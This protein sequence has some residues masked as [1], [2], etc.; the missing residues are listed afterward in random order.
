MPLVVRSGGGREG[1]AGGREGTNWNTGRL[2]CYQ[3]LPIIAAD[4]KALLEGGP[5]DVEEGNIP[6]HVTLTLALLILRLSNYS[7]PYCITPNHHHHFITTTP[8][9][10]S[11]HHHGVKFTHACHSHTQTYFL[12][13]TF[14]ITTSIRVF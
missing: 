10:P 2:V 6:G 11:T 5:R 1:V 8:H 13:N 14:T 9:T 7:E 4:S 3:T 12:I